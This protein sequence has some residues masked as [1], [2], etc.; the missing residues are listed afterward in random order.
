[1]EDNIYLSVVVP[2]FNERENIARLHEEII[3]AFEN[4]AASYEL[5]YVNDG[6]T[7]G[8]A[9]VLASL[10]GCTVVTMQRSFGQTAALVAG[11]EIARGEM[12]ATLDGD[13]QNDPRDL[14]PMLMSLDNEKQDFVIGWR[15]QRKD[16]LLK[17]LVSWGA[18]GLRQILLHDG[19]HDAGCGTKVF[20]ARV[21]NDVELYGEMHRFFVSIVKSKGYVVSEYRVSHRA[22][23]YGVSKYSWKR[24]IKGFLDMIAVWF[25]GRFSARPLHILG[26]IGLLVIFLSFVTF[27]VVMTHAARDYGFL[28]TQN[29]VIAAILMFLLGVQL[30]VSG[31][32]AD[33]VV[34]GY[35]ASSGKKN[36]VVRDVKRQC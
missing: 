8:S 35:F 22:R 32:V 9:E 5:I 24:A 31:L 18:Y 36:Y 6:S 4:F 28:N 14:I 10:S 30:L 23:I 16:P 34:R 12:I 15:K 29:W 33:I 13:L 20:R 27:V 1:M 19:I 25:W 17:K 3:S 21:M 2:F 11:I 26:G 7:D